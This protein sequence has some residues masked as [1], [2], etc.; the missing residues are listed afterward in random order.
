M[1]SQS[2]QLALLRRANAGIRAIDPELDEEMADTGA[3]SESMSSLRTDIE[4]ESIVMRRLKPVLSIQDGATTLQFG[5]VS[6]STIWKDKLVAAARLLQPAISAL[7]RIQVSGDPD[8]PDRFGRAVRRARRGRHRAAC[9]SLRQATG[10]SAMIRFQ[11]STNA[12]H[13]S[14]NEFQ[15]RVS[16]DHASSSEFQSSLSADHS[17]V[18]EIQS[19]VSEIQSWLS[20]DH[21]GLSEFQSSSST[22]SL[23]RD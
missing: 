13:P 6:E 10:G 20:G 1:S 21:S 9:P 3:R 14:V 19:P 11:P 8:G 18:G 17:S 16:G 22:A 12:D 7:G 23:T 2:E 5:D 4:Q 15:S